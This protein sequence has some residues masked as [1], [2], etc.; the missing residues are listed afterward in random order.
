MLINLKTLACSEISEDQLLTF[1]YNF[2]KLLTR[3]NCDNNY[4]DFFF[5]YSSGKVYMDIDILWCS[6]FEYSDGSA[7]GP[8][9]AS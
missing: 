9:S 1:P 7:F 5:I 3:L 4:L 6:P 8:W 2:V